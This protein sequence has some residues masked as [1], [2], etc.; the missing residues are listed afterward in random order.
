MNVL[1]WCPFAHLFDTPFQNSPLRP[2]SNFCRLYK[3][4]RVSILYMSCFLEADVREQQQYEKRIQT[5]LDNVVN[6]LV[7]RSGLKI[8]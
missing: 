2:W 4:G 8:V 1:C 7:M 6:D 5:Y 3:Y